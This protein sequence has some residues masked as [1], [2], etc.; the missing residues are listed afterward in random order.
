MQKL[1]KP[2]EMYVRYQSMLSVRECSLSLFA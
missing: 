2:Y 1:C